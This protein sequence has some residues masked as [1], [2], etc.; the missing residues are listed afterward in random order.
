M[1]SSLYPFFDQT[2]SQNDAK[3]FPSIVAAQGKLCTV[4]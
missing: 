1:A 3:D 2:I 4:P